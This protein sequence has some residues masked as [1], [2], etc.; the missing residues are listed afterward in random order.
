MRLYNRSV[1]PKPPERPATPPPVPPSSASPIAVPAGPLPDPHLLER[2][3]ALEAKVAALEA[4]VGA[5][6]AADLQGM[7][8]PRPGSDATEAVRP[9]GLRAFP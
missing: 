1:S 7:R 4:Q 6:A 9:S 8:A 5:P 2:I 3:R